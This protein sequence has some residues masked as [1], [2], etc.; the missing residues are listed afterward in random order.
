[1]RKYAG[2]ALLAL[3]AVLLLAG[4]CFAEELYPG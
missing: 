1:M 2:K 4:A 3:M